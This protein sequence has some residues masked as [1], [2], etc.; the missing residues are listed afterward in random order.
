MVPNM[1]GFNKVENMMMSFPVFDAFL[2]FGRSS[3]Y[4]NIY[5]FPDLKD[6]YWS[7]FFG[8]AHISRRSK[9]VTARPY[10]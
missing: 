6:V 4:P 3:P 7:R 1:A 8:S 5:T 9:T 2:F 10:R